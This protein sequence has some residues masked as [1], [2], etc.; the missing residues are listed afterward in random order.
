MGYRHI[1]SN[2]I[3]EVTEGKQFKTCLSIR[4]NQVKPIGM[5]CSSV[6]RVSLVMKV[7]KDAGSKPVRSS[8]LE[9]K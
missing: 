5:T 1:G 9:S 8:A 7:E 2:P 6:G 4:D 3:R